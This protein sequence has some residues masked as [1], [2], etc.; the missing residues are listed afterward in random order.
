MAMAG[1]RIIVNADDLGLAPSVNEAIFATHRVGNVNSATLMVDMPGTADAVARLVAHP[2]LAVGLHFRITEGVALTGRSSLTDAQGHFHDRFAMARAILRGNIVVA[3]IRAEFEAQL[4]RMR[5]LGVPT[6]HVDSHQ[7]V[8]MSPP[9]LRAV[10][11]V[12]EREGLPM[13]LVRPPWRTVL[14]DLGRPGRATRQLLNVLLARRCRALHKGQHNGHLVSVHDL[15]SP[16]PYSASDYHALIARV[17]TG[18]VVEVMVHPYILGEDVLGL[19]GPALDSK[20]PFLQRCAAEYEI[21][22]GPPIF[23]AYTMTTFREL[24]AV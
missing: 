16:G 4:A 23:G 20:M 2:K 22:K 3:D 12:L 13:R 17:P 24:T 18:G 11:P 5:E 19:Y 9:I 8:L 6:G 14:G 21:L 10:A 15:P 1:R 7:H